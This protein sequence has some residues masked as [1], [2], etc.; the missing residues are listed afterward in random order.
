MNH[1]VFTAAHTLVMGIVNVTP[2]SFSDGGQLKNAAAAIS[3]ARKLVAEGAEIVDVGGESTRPGSDPV[4]VEEELRR[5]LPVIEQL[6]AD[7]AAVISIDTRK[8]EVADVCLRA[9]AR[10]VND[11]GGLRE[12]DMAATAARHGVA[13]VIMHM[14]GT[15][16]TM[17]I[18]P[19]YG[20]VVLDISAYL[21]SQAEKAREAGIKDIAI[22]PGIGFG[23]T[24][25]HNLEILNRLAEFGKLGYPV[26]VG[27]S[28]K[29]FLGKITGMEEDKR[30]IEGTIAACVVAAMRGASVLR[31]HDVAECKRALRVA[32]A[33]RSAGE[34]AS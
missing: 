1:S 12:P 32:D 5:V 6:V 13:V 20:D 10:I 19:H 14:Q 9:G 30:R 8:P 26:L 31:V 11:V 29:A 22:D 34:K 27:P 16:K 21:A 25:D 4:T 7:G 24:T 15:P 2:D 17:Q 33:I 18:A 23:K 28:R 3:H